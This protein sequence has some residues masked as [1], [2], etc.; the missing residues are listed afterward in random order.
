MKRDFLEDV[1]FDESRL[2]TLILVLTEYLEDNGAKKGQ[3]VPLNSDGTAPS[4]DTVCEL[5]GSS[6]L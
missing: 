4:A 1:I 6:A 2:E 3:F 5:L